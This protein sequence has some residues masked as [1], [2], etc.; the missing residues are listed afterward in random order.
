MIHDSIIPKECEVTG[1][2]KPEGVRPRS[3]NHRSS[4]ILRGN[5]SVSGI[6]EGGSNCEVEWA[7]VQIFFFNSELKIKNAKRR[8]FGSSNSSSNRFIT[9]P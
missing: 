4:E 2:K 9:E 3:Q 5:D 8:H 1:I 6:L 7:I